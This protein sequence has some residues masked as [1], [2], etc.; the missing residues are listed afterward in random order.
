[1]TA[2]FLALG[3]VAFAL[4]FGWELAHAKWYVTMNAL[5]FLTATAW[6]ARAALIDVAISAGAYAAAALIAR[7][8]RW[9]SA[10]RAFPVAVYFAIGLAITVAI[11]RWAIAVGRWRYA[12]TMPTIGGIGL[13]PLLQWIV[14]PLLIAAAARLIVSPRRSPR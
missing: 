4:H 5:P 14:L 10:L 9:V 11:E 7:S 12:P 2:R 8:L 3:V 6:C 13:S 1:M